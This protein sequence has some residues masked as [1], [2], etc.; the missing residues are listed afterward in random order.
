MY[1]QPSSVFSRNGS[2]ILSGALCE[3]VDI[4]VEEVCVHRSPAKSGRHRLDHPSRA[5]ALCDPACHSTESC[6]V[7]SAEM[8]VARRVFRSE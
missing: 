6:G 8:P 1:I 3:Q 4:G 5:A 7:R 2:E